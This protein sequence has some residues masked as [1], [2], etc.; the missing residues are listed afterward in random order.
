MIGGVGKEMVCAIEQVMIGVIR[1]VQSMK[2]VA[3]GSDTTMARSLC[4]VLF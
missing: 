4:A 1:A 3:K 2:G